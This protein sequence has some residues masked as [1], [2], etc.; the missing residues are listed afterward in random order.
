MNCFTGCLE[1]QGLHLNLITV[2]KTEL[3]ELLRHFYGSV[4]NGEGGL[5]HTD[6][7]LRAG[8]NC[9]SCQLSSV[10]KGAEFTSATMVFLGVLKR[11]PAETYTIRHCPLWTSISSDRHMWWRPA[12]REVFWTKSGLNIWVHFGH[13]VKQANGKLKSDSF[14]IGKDKKGLRYCKTSRWNW[15]VLHFLRGHTVISVPFLSLSGLREAGMSV[16]YTNHNRDR[17]GRDMF[18]AQVGCVYSPVAVWMYVYP[19][20]LKFNFYSQSMKSL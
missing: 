6:P 10:Y 7:A 4:Q 14:E 18:P 2:E 5:Y 19:F 13:R 16:T 1:S 15:L 8:I 20:R 9:E 17:R 3:N 11:S 12:L